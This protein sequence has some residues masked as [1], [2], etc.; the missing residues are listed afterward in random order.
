MIKLTKIEKRLVK[1]W[2]KL[3]GID[4]KETCPFVLLFNNSRDSAL[5]HKSIC[6]RLFKKTKKYLLEDSIGIKF[7]PCCL[8]PKKYVVRRAKEWTSG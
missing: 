4:Q 2:L 6:G 8:Y 3:P 5:V 1:E 7:C